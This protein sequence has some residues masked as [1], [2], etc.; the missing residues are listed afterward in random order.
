[1][2][3]AK[4]TETSQKDTRSE[5]EEETIKQGENV[6]NE[7]TPPLNEKVQRMLREMAQSGG[8]Q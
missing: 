8:N 1:M 5:S 7:T 3:P 6:A 2:T 4:K